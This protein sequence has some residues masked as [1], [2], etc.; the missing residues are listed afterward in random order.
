M[1]RQVKVGNVLVGGGAPVSVQSMCSTDT[2]DIPA[3]LTQ[4]RA[5]HDAG[6]EIARVAVPDGQAA[7][8]LGKLCK[9]SPLPLVA[10]IHFDYKLAIQAANAGAAKIRVNPGNIGSREKVRAVAD[11]CRE[12]GIPIRIGVN[13]GSVDR[14][15]LARYG[16]VEA[17]TRSAL[18]Q[19]GTLEEMG[20]TDV[21]L[22]LK[23]SNVRDTIAATR[24]V[25]AQTDAPLHLGVTEAG[26]S[27]HG[28]IKSA[29]GIGALLL[30]G[31]GDTIRVSL[32]AP[33]VE[34]VR[35]AIALLKAVGLRSGGVDIIS[36]PACARRGIDVA[37][38]AHEVERRLS[39]ITAPIKIAVMGCVVNGPGEARDADIG[40]APDGNGQAVWFRKGEVIGRIDEAEI[41]DILTKEA[42]ELLR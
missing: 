20:F 31:I 26:T 39:D 9:E 30:D 5:L 1:T 35:A 17:M 21:C 10:D 24:A 40:V 41:A 32:T 34:E 3:T 12:R 27:Y 16:L 2:R 11:A 6:C 13:G 14:E 25:A 29:A 33:P 22:S 37:A 23:A 19:L 18:E 4:L 7:Q 28:V 36:C 8:A 15:L 38:L 42:R